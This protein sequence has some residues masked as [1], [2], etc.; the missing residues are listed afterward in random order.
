MPTVQ[1]DGASVA[2]RVDGEGPALVLVAGTGGNLESNWAHVMPA[3]QARHTVL[4]VDY[5]GSSG[6]T[7]DETAVLTVERLAS[8]VAAAIDDAGL[9][10]FHL[11]GYSLGSSIALQTAAIF[12]DRV[13]SLTLLAG[14]ASGRDTRFAL[15][16]QLWL[17]LIR[18]DPRQFARLIILTGLSPQAVSSFQESDVRL[19]EDAICANN[20]WEGISRQIGLD[21]TLDVSAILPAIR[22]PTLSIGCTHDHM[23]PPQHAR[24]LAA[25]IAGA[26]YHELSCGHLAPFEQ[27]DAFLEAL[28]DFTGQH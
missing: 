14:F 2:Y 23:V 21:A 15:Q 19:W 1:I 16:S 20:D 7:R 12:A 10:R 28:N 4:R 3:L 24:H 18:H 22:V 11:A 8:Q 27:P 6:G 13:R 9:D 17:D 25:T 5:A 26:R